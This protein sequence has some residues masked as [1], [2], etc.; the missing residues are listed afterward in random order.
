MNAHIVEIMKVATSELFT[1]LQQGKTDDSLFFFPSWISDIR[2][3]LMFAAWKRALLLL[4]LLPL[5]YHHNTNFY[6]K[7]HI[8]TFAQRDKPYT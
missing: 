7:M 3:Q 6:P 4:C 1:N 8:V 5:V 2:F